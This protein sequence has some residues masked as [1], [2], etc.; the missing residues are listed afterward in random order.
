MHT[1]RYLLQGPILGRDNRNIV[2]Y[3]NTTF[4]LLSMNHKD[5]KWTLILCNIIDK[6]QQ[7][8]LRVGATK[9]SDL[10][11]IRAARHYKRKQQEL[12]NVLY[13]SSHITVEMIIIISPI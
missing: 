7:R 4:K 10:R 1:T 3:V 6:I 8:L 13:F 12:G 5:Y 11:V 9:T 2:I